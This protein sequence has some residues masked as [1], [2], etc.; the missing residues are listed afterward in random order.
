[1]KE[2]RYDAKMVKK[3]EALLVGLPYWKDNQDTV[4]GTSESF[5]WEFDPVGG[6]QVANSLTLGYERLGVASLGITS[7][8]VAAGKEEP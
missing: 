5:P 6:A 3:I 2:D 4:A 8:V 7:A 1:M